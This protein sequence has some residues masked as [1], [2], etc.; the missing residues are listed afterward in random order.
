MFAVESSLYWIVACSISAP[1]WL[2]PL[3]KLLP[4]NKTSLSLSLLILSAAAAVVWDVGTPCFHFPRLYNTK[5]LSG[6]YRSA[7][8]N[9][10]PAGSKCY[11]PHVDKDYPDL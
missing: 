2:L 4:G 8:S 9:Q 1:G 10:S 7:V 3:E 6:L 11:K 5:T